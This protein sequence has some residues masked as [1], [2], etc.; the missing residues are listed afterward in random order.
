MAR[1]VTRRW[2][3]R[4]RAVLGRR[5]VD[6]E[7]QEEFSFHLEQQTAKYVAEGMSA[8]E[9]RRRAAVDFGGVERYREEVR[10]ARYLSWVH[11]LARDL[12]YVIR[13]LSHRPGF[14]AAILLTLSVSIGA[15]VA[16]FATANALFFRPL[17]FTHESR[18]QRIYETNPEFGWTDADAAPANFLDWRANV[19]AFE[20]VAAYMGFRSQSTWVENGEPRILDVSDVTGNFFDVLGVRP[21]LGRAFTWEETWSD[22][23]KVAVISHATWEQHFHADSAVVGRSIQL[24]SDTYQII[25]VMPRDFTFPNEG[26]HVWKTFGWDH[27]NYAQVSFR[28]AHYI[29]PIAK[30]RAGVTT[31][32]ANSALQVEVERLKLAYPGTNRVMG[33][34]V[35]PLRDFLLADLRQPVLMLAGAVAVLLLLACANVANL[36]L[37]RALARQQEL[38]LRGALGAGR[39]RLAAMIMTEHWTLA[40]AGGML[41]TALSWG[42]FRLRGIPAFG[43]PA[44]NSVVFDYRVGLFAVGLT[45]LCAILFSAAPLAMAAQQGDGQVRSNQQRATG[46]SRLQRLT[47][48]L[49]AVEVAL[50]VIL[51]AGAALMA[52]TAYRLRHVDVGFRSDN[53]LAV[54]FSL[55]E[56]RYPNREATTAFYDRLIETLEARPGIERAGT[57]G[58]LPLNG[59]SWSS[60]FR[61]AGWPEERVG[62]EILHRRADRGY[63][64]ALGVPLVRG[65]FVDETDRAGTPPVVVIN[66][67]F[68]KAHFPGEDPVGKRIVF[69]RAPDANSIW[70]DIVGVVGDQNQESPATPTRPEVFESRTQSGGRNN[71]LVIRTANAPMDAVP[72]VR[73]TLRELDPL[74]PIATL[75]TLEEVRRSS[76]KRQYG[77]LGM[78]GA[79]GI[80]ALFL[81][82]VGV[83]AVA[84]QSARQR[85]REIGIRLALGAAPPDILRLVLRRGVAALTL[86]LGLGLAVTLAATRALSSLLY[87]V[88][89]TDPTTLAAVALVLLGV[90]TAACWIPARQAARLDPVMSLKME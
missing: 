7:L 83:Y 39:A 1:S 49:V 12:R 33:A 47:N 76:M 84:A 66:E 58:Q 17:P 20:D 51:V 75:R 29:R 86:G 78:L 14:I 61:I 57:V 30:L 87:G 32:L 52:Q 18:L 59:A 26:T 81:A 48:A 69:D 80:L 13:G 44:A 34:G 5:T 65:R 2:I 73:T 10:E 45:V 42:A 31:E 70:Y 68:A 60:Q 41:G 46:S 62:N 15:C 72:T 4:L 67:A 90:G 27:A 50:A 22:A 53:V 25:G 6:E 16:M 8:A 63:F 28:R 24:D 89:A 21:A 88:N 74:I 82:T 23:S 85:T 40:I 56:S 37:L 77:V 3:R 43:V 79:F 11:H 9:A 19:K 35:T 71:W 64:E 55:P 54:Q 38:A 36:A